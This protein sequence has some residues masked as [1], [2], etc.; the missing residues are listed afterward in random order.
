M[1]YHLTNKQSLGPDVTG[2]ITGAADRKVSWTQEGFRVLFQTLGLLFLSGLFFC[3]YS[4][5]VT[6]RRRLQVCHRPSW[7]TVQFL[8]PWQLCLGVPRIPSRLE[9]IFLSANNTVEPMIVNRY[10]RAVQS[11][12]R[13]RV[14]GLCW[15]SNADIDFEEDISCWGKTVSTFVALQSFPH[16]S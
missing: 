7:Y 11:R 4:S 16:G 2:V 10:L 13:R 5:P 1:W 12:Y 15:Y 14:L 6:R 3:A 8:T 9:R